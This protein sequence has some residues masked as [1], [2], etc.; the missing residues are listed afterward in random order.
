MLLKIVTIN[1]PTPHNKQQL[2]NEEQE[3]P[4][5][6][7]KVRYSPTSAARRPLP[8]MIAACNLHRRLNLKRAATRCGERPSSRGRVRASA[9]ARGLANPAAALTKVFFF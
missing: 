9:M 8:R 6:E 7:R 2:S 5:T 4:Q 1:P 3:T